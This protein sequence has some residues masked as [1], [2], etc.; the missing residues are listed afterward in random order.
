MN[1]NI[2]V[3]GLVIV[4]I[5]FAIFIIAKHDK[6]KYEIKEQ[7][8]PKVKTRI[9]NTK[10]EH[11]SGLATFLQVFGILNILVGVGL[12]AVTKIDAGVLSIISSLLLFAVAEIVYHIQWQSKILNK[13]LEVSNKTEPV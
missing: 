10:V 12:I 9:N 8:E 4:L 13:I 11:Y 1:T 5:A 7:P 6:K 3:P 2:I